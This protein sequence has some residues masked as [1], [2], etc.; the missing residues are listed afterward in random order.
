MNDGHKQLIL[1]DSRRLTGANLFWGSPA[2]IIDVSFG[3]PASDADTATITR[4]WQRAARRLLELTGRTGARTTHRVFEGGASYL[5]SAPIDALYSMCEL[6]ETAWSLALAELDAG[7]PL[8]EQSEAKRL[9]QLFAA[10]ARPA[11]L[12][13]QRAAHDHGVPFL[14]D[15]DEVSLGYGASARTWPSDSLPDP[16]GVDWNTIGAIP[17]ALVTGTNGKS[18]TV[19]MA[20]AMIAAAGLRAGLTSTDWIRVGSTILDTG[21]Y[22][23]TGGARTLLRHP[24]TE[25][26]V[27]E[28]ARGGLLRRGLGVERAD[29][30][31]ITNVDADHLGEY[32]INT[33]PELIEAKFIVRRALHAQAPLILNA[34]D[35]GIV[36]FTGRLE[37]PVI[38]FGLHPERPPLREALA[39]GATAACL[40]QGWLTLHQGGQARRIIEASAIPA[41]VGGAA[42]HNIR[43]ALGAMVLCHA[44]GVA[45]QALRAGL[46]GFRGD[47]ADNPGRGNWFEGKGV[48]ILVDFAHNE[49][50]MRALT[51]M[52]VQ[53][54]AKRRIVLM[55]QAG[56]R[57]DR[58]I[59]RMTSVVC[60]LRPDRLMAC[61]LPGYERGR[62]AKEVPGII[63]QA[64]LDEGI[65]PESVDLFDTPTLAAED[66]LNHARPGDLLVFLAL[67]Q[68]ADVLERVHRFVGDPPTETAQNP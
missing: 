28:T 18:T 46:A 19:R 11:L 67:T 17:A 13:L 40:E 4:A 7:P 3:A 48:K 51:E 2:A 31:L 60:Q 15:D 68:R 20:A 33:V 52:L 53:V 1:T 66:A 55:G 56:D 64:A 32:G 9:Q 57:L 27:L 49:H 5:I 34:D 42:L 26:A 24:E 30:A 6:N 35:P 16:Q 21:D 50:G 14:W 12:A 8:D 59:R 62:A 23:G 10:E 65:A 37:Q 45:D 63:R 58:D 41:T 25:I 61:D 44:L 47:E 29:A 43:N 38:W 54:Q 36:E 39:A 22:S